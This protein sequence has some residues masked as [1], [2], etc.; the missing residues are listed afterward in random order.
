MTSMRIPHPFTSRADHRDRVLQR[1]ERL[2]QT[3][4]QL[5]AEAQEVL[6]DVRVELQKDAGSTPRR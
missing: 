5:L 2:V 1:A 4:E 3:T 6:K